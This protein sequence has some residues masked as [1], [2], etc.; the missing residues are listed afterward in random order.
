MF[1]HWQETAYV[2]SESDSEI[3][4]GNDTTNPLSSIHLIEYHFP[5][6]RAPCPMVWKTALDSM[7][8]A[9][10]ISRGLITP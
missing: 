6:L 4:G 1:K 5:N 8:A 2:N 9:G 3:N 7:T 10:K